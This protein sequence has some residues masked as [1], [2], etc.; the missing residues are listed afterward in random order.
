MKK[1]NL[2]IS[3]LYIN[4][5][6]L[7]IINT[8]FGKVFIELIVWII[9][10]VEPDFTDFYDPS[11]FYAKLFIV[12]SLWFIAY[13]VLSVINIISIALDY[14]N[15]NLEHIFQKMKRIKI[16]FSIFELYLNFLKKVI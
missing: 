11:N 2:L 16:N 13:F 7:I 4:S 9:S 5:L 12:F 3:A 1:V 6:I 15:N 10:I 8:Y 14:R